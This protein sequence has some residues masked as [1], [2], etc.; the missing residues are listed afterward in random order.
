MKPILLLLALAGLTGCSSAM[1]RAQESVT[2][3]LPAVETIEFRQLAAYPG[4][5]ICGHYRSIQRYGD[6]PGF[7]PFIVR[8]EHTNVLPSTQD[9][10]IFCTADPAA[11]LY[12]LTGIQAHPA[13]TAKLE[14]IAQDLARLQ[15][16]LQDYYADIANYPQ[17]DPGLESLIKPV[18]SMRRAGKFREGGYLQALPVDP[19]QRAYRYAAPDFAGSHQPPSLLTLGADGRPGG[20]DEN[21]DISLQE[22]HYL[23]HVLK[24][25]AR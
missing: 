12:E 24:L 15:N 10:S 21:A 2:A 22:L 17:S 18:G 13:S 7:K 9:I 20:T 25:P 14:K 1:Q 6:S 5:V 11:T 4:D 8:A 23:Q 16:A 3:A 19:W